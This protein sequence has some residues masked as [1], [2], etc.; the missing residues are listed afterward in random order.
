MDIPFEP[1]T[2]GLPLADSAA[3]TSNIIP[4][5]P[6]PAQGRVFADED[7]RIGYEVAQTVLRLTATLPHEGTELRTQLISFDPADELRGLSAIL[8]AGTVIFTGHGG[9]VLVPERSLQILHTL[10]IPFHDHPFVPNPTK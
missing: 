8:T 9:I 4:P 5:E 2:E 7:T 6:T 3:E 10:G 1:V